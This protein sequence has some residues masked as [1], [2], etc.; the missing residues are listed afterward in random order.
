MTL[1]ELERLTEAID[2]DDAA[3]VFPLHDEDDDSFVGLWVQHGG[4]RSSVTVEDLDG[5]D[6]LDF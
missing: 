3:E 4:V 6:E 5:S 2:E 1:G